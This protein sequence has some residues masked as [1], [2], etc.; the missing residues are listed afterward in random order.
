MGKT[1]R[2]DFYLL[3]CRLLTVFILILT[4]GCSLK[5]EA[6]PDLM[7]SSNS[8]IIINTALLM[9]CFSISV[10]CTVLLKFPKAKLSAFPV[11]LKLQNYLVLRMKYSVIHSDSK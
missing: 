5:D 7:V 2:V 6:C 4:T 11:L 8:H 9:S 1:T 3:C 10:F